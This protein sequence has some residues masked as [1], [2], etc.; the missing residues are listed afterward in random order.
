[1]ASSSENSG[2]EPNNPPISVAPSL[3]SVMMI[4]TTPSAIPPSAIPLRALPAVTMPP[5]SPLAPQRPFLSF[6]SP[7]FPSFSQNPLPHTYPS[8]SS[9]P[10]PPIFNVPPT[11]IPFPMARLVPLPPFLPSTPTLVSLFRIFLKPSLLNYLIQT[12]YFGRIRSL[13][14][15]WATT[16]ECFIEVRSLN[17]QN[18]WV[19]KELRSKAG[20]FKPKA[21]LSIVVDLDKV[22]LRSHEDAPLHL[23]WKQAMVFIIS[24][25]SKILETCLS[26]GI[27]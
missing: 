7:N 13:I 3:L 18:F 2:K 12:T 8:Q 27:Q 23:K 6:R 15:S 21:W 16:L 10:Y 5:I 24:L 9:F 19:L 22:E 14:S 4:S 25:L 26:H 1:M 17:L 20:I 11:N